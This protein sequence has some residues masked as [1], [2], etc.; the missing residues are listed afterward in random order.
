MFFQLLPN[1]I[2]RDLKNAV[3]NNE[4]TQKLR[5]LLLTRKKSIYVNNYVVFIFRNSII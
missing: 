2:K 4:V 5:G 1:L 3:F